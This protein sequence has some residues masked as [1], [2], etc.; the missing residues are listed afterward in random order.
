M[1][2]R[3]QSQDLEHKGPS[4]NPLERRQREIDGRAA[5]IPRKEFDREAESGVEQPDEAAH[6]R[7]KSS[8]P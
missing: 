4:S 3:P 6:P 5:K 2:N 8:A 1:G 7:V